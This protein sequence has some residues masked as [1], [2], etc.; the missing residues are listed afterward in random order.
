MYPRAHVH[1]RWSMN[2]AATVDRKVTVGSNDFG[3]SVDRMFPKISC[4]NVAGAR[5]ILTTSSFVPTLF[6]FL[7]E[8][9]FQ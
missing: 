5:L 6:R 9:S 7:N 4:K 2:R 8:Y 3:S 1:Q